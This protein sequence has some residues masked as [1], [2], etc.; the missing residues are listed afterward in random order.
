ME[1]NL[2]YLQFVLLQYSHD[3]EIETQFSF[4]FLNKFSCDLLWVQLFL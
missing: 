4:T 2:F 3:Y 1:D